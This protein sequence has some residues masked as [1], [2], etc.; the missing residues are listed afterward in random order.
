MSLCFNIIMPAFACCHLGNPQ[1]YGQC[2]FSEKEAEVLI[3]SAS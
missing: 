1:F 2:Q 3:S